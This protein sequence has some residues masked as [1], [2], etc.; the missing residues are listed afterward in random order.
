MDSAEGRSIL[1]VIRSTDNI[2]HVHTPGAAP[3]SK[4]ER[5]SLLSAYDSHLSDLTREVK[6][7]T[8]VRDPAGN[9]K[10]CAKA[11]LDAYFDNKVIKKL[12]VF[13]RVVRER[14]DVIACTSSDVSSRCVSRAVFFSVVGLGHHSVSTPPMWS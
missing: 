10:G 12:Q 1:R 3:I 11:W 13:L 6:P 7:E 9:D 5:A 8:F 14:V 4:T 2:I